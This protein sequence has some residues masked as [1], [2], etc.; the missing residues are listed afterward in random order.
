MQHKPNNKD[1]VYPRA[2]G[3]TVLL[4]ATKKPVIGLSPRLRGNRLQPRR[5]DPGERSIP[6]PAGEPVEAASVRGA[7]SVYPRACGGTAQAVR[8]ALTEWG[9]SPRLR[10]NQPAR[11]LHAGTGWSIPAPAGEPGRHQRQLFHGQVYPRA[12]GGTHETYGRFHGRKGLSPRLRGNHG[13]GISDGGGMRSIPAPA[14]EPLGE[15]S[16]MPLREVYPRACGGTV[17]GGL[18]LR[19]G[20]GLSPRL[21]GNR[22]PEPGAGER[23]RSIPAP[24][25]EPGNYPRGTIPAWVYPRA[26]GGTLRRPKQLHL[27]PGLSPRLRGNRNRLHPRGHLRRSIPAPA[28]EPQRSTGPT[29]PDPVYPRACGGTVCNVTHPDPAA[30]L[31][32]R[33]RGNQSHDV[34]TGLVVR[35]IPAPAGE[36]AP[37]PHH[38]PRLRVYPRACGGTTESMRRSTSSR[39]LSPRLRGNPER[40]QLGTRA[41]RSIPAPAG[42]PWPSR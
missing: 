30:G 4:S 8:D 17:R 15:A 5:P 27:L 32:P 35:S 34:G 6:A 21:R 36:P 40:Q 14:G 10:G 38:P 33:L 13:I 9:L 22:L 39:G 42:E 23:R 19:A 25:G 1:K 3:G 2:C 7:R 26:C 31:S 12:C 20:C 29:P 18:C 37:R 28:G 11:D 24:A 16:L 41:E